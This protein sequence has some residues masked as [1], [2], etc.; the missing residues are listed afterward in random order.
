MTSI[1]VNAYSAAD[2]ERVMRE[3]HASS[4][5]PTIIYDAGHRFRLVREWKGRRFVYRVPLK[6]VLK[7]LGTLP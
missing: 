5:L 7:S 1:T 2:I 3:F 4:E 6:V